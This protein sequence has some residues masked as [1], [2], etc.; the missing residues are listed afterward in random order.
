VYM[1]L[2][3]SQSSYAF[4][5]IVFHIVLRCYSRTVYC[6]FSIVIVHL[7]MNVHK[8]TTCMYIMLQSAV[9]QWLMWTCSGVGRSAASMLD[10]VGWTRQ[11]GRL[12]Q[13]N[14]ASKPL[15]MAVNVSG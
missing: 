4:I 11:E 1:M 9:Q 15:G 3:N 13:K 7:Y 2:I 14:S 5:R 12:A 8:C 6:A 10:A